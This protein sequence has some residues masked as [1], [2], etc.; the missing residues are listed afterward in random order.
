MKLV[1]W[2]RFTWSLANL[3]AAEDI[4]LDPRYRIR[5][6][7]RDEEKTVHDVVLRAFALDP[8]WSD[9]LKGIQDWLETQIDETFSHRGV[10][11]LVVTH[12]S[13]IIGA[14]LLDGDS[15]AESNLITGPSILNEYRCRGI[16]TALLHQSL[17]ALR[18]TGLSQARAITKN[19]APAAKFV[20]PK[21][22]SVSEPVDF[23]AQMAL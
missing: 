15:Q 5:P 13:R 22:G 2:T 8:D 18:E 17:C 20:Y 3:P 19:N 16:G 9:T 11:C 23:A 14:S 10:T 6:A 7:S 21:F 4:S 1:R 12:G